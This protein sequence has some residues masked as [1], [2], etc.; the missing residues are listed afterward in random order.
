MLYNGKKIAGILLEMQGDA[1][2]DVSVVIGVGVNVS[3]QQDN[4]LASQIDQPWTGL[5]SIADRP[6]DRNRLLAVVVA[7][8]VENLQ[9]FELKGFSEFNE[10]WHK[11]HVYQDSFVR[12]IIGDNEIE[13]VCRGVNAQGALLLER[14][15]KIE[16]YHG[17]EISVR[18]G[19][20]EAD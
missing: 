15:G 9:L 18:K 1:S 16:A 13:G 6:I 3:M 14:Y 2:G 12:L 5:S 11:L 10:R 17:G 7:Q 8:L 19:Q 20:R 4:P